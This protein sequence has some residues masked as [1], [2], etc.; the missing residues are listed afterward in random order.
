MQFATYQDFAVQVLRL[1]DG[2]DVASDLSPDTLDALI[3]LGETRVYR[4]LRASTMEAPLS[5][6]VTSN[7]ATLPTDC[8]ALSTVWF[9]GEK[10]LNVAPEQ[11]LRDKL[12]WTNGGTPRLVAMA[13]EEVIFYPPATDASLLTGRYYARPDDLKTA[14]NPTFARYPEVF[15]YAALCESAPLLGEEPRLAMWT[16]L[17]VRYMETANTQEIHRAYSGSRLRQVAR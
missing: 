16:S 8:I 13:G 10:P 11:E 12:R 4:D 7:T 5:I 14:L 3:A 1:I 15:I 17:Y 6:A 2:D 9:A